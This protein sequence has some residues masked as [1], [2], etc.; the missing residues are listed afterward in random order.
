ME[1]AHGG[2]KVQIGIHDLAGRLHVDE[3][4][5]RAHLRGGRSTRRQHSLKAQ[6]LVKFEAAG[7]TVSHAVQ[8]KRVRGPDIYT[9]APGESHS[10]VPVGR[11]AALSATER[12]HPADDHGFEGELSAE[13]AEFKQVQ[14]ASDDEFVEGLVARLAGRTTWFR[15]DHPQARWFVHVVADLIRGGWPEEILMERLCL[16]P[17]AP[18]RPAMQR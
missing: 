8:K 9:L 4:T 1:L 12:Q 2:W 17:V 10:T 6:R 18:A 14:P 5:V 16:V 13:K 15:D 11:E 7:H 3:S